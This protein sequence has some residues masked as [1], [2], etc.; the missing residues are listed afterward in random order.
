MVINTYK[1]HKALVIE[2]IITDLLFKDFWSAE[3]DFYGTS[4]LKQQSHV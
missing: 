3:L 4:S 1:V 2:N